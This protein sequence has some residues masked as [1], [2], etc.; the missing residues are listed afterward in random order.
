V[1]QNPNRDDY[2]LGYGL[3]DENTWRQVHMRMDRDDGVVV[4]IQ[5]LRPIDWIEASGLFPGGEYEVDLPHTSARGIARVLDIAPCPMLA[6]GDGNLVI[7][8]F[9][10]RDAK[11]LVKVTFEDGTTLTGTRIHPVWSLNRRDWIELGKLEV[12]ENLQGANGP[13]TVQYLTYIATSQPVYNL[14]IFREHVYRVGLAGVLCHNTDPDKCTYILKP[15]SELADV[16]TL[17]GRQVASEFSGN[18]IKRIKKDMK[19]TGFDPTQPIEV[20]VVNGKNIIWNGHHRARAAGA[21]GIKQVPI[22]LL[23]KPPEVMGKLWNEAAEA[24]QQ[25]GLPF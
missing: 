9:E 1:G 25:L 8:R 11:E 15:V 20:V 2:D 12:G 18:L 16:S 4:D 5:L 22:V 21:A 24:A 10:T 6:N 19:L 14:E 23:E 3:P 17:K 13:I 7:G